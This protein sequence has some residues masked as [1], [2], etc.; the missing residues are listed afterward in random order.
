MTPDAYPDTPLTRHFL[1]HVREGDAYPGETWLAVA[2][3]ASFLAT[4]AAILG[5][6]WWML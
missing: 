2:F 1:D 6:L 4:L 5:F 3:T